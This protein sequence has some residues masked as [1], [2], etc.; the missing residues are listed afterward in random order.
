MMRKNLLFFLIIVYLKKM[1]MFLKNLN[2]YFLYLLN[3]DYHLS[4]NYLLSKCN[5]KKNCF[6]FWALERNEFLIKKYFY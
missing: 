6:T 5:Y 4:Q 3:I 2:F 1:N